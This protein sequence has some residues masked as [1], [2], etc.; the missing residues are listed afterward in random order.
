MANKSLATL[1]AEHAALKAQWIKAR[2]MSNMADDDA[3]ELALQNEER[4]WDEMCVVRQ[5]LYSMIEEIR[6]AM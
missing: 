6:A 4:I 3:Y 2:D 5:R 1:T